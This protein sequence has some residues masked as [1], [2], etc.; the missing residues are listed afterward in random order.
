MTIEL[1]PSDIQAVLEAQQAVNLAVA[2]VQALA[3]ADN[4]LLAEISIDLISQLREIDQKLTRIATLIQ[5]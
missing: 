5:H 4:P 1:T 3:S 2:P